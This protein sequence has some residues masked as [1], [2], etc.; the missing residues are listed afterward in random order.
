MIVL[1]LA[2]KVAARDAEIC[3]SAVVRGRLCE[4]SLTHSRPVPAAGGRTGCAYAKTYVDRQTHDSALA[5]RFDTARSVCLDMRKSSDSHR[6]PSLS[7]R[8]VGS[9]VSRHAQDGGFQ[10]VE[11]KRRR[12][13]LSVVAVVT[14]A[15]TAIML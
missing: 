6:Y 13:A 15:V 1:G 8:F 12:P 9:R 10:A 3:R 14:A 5:K 7:G 2:H 4:D 11:V